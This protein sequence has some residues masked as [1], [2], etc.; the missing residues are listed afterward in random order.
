MNHEDEN[1]G[2]DGLGCD[3]A[4]ATVP[5]DCTSERAVGNF[6]LG[7]WFGDV[8]CRTF[9]VVGSNLMSGWRQE[10]ED[11]WE[12]NRRSVRRCRFLDER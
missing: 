5:N 12:R 1:G 6:L 11:F 10:S 4:C 3:R 8:P 2:C 9:I 7:E